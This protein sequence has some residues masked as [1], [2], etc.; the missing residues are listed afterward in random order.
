MAGDYLAQVRHY[1]R[2]FDQALTTQYS[3]SIRIDPDGLSFSVYSHLVS[4]FIA[5][6]SINLQNSTAFS[7][8]ESAKALIIDR[9]NDFFNQHPW[10]LKPF[11]HT[12][13]LIN[14][15][16]YTLVPHALYDPSQ[17]ETYLD[18]VHN[19]VKSG[20]ILDHFLNSAEAWV[21]FS[22]NKNLSE[23]LNRNFSNA[24]LLHH[25]GAMIETLLP[26][27]RHSELRNPV[28]VNIRTGSFDIIVLKEGKLL[29]CNSFEWK[30]NEDL[31]YYLIFVLDQLNLNPE[32]VPVI[33]SGGIDPESLLF[34]LIQR[35][36][37]HVD[38]IKNPASSVPGIS[39]PH[40]SGYK[41]YDLLNPVL[42]G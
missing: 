37:R 31:V 40:S 10:I 28:F 32:N 12:C 22:I 4:R 38:L 26:R 19:H 41:Y 30:T 36:I 8:G 25:A 35:Y 3:L 5:L 14:S 2:L 6:E 20:I 9:L 17:K 34:E 18:F 21:V 16:C 7:S 13:L 29:Y 15:L 33:L 1:D 24:K 27:Y 11:R 39:I 42:C 23:L